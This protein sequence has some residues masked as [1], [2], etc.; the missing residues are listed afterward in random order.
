MK[1]ITILYRQ[2]NYKNADK[3]IGSLRQSLKHSLR[4]TPSNPTK[5]LE[6]DEDKSSENQ[7]YD[8]ESNKIK[9]LDSLSQDERIALIK[10]I[11]DD[12]KINVKANNIDTTNK[13][14]LSKYR[15]KLNK[16]IKQSVDNPELCSYLNQI[17]SAKT[18]LDADE[19]KTKFGQ[20]QMS[21][22]K[23]K[24]NCLGKFIELHNK[25]LTPSNKKEFVL[26][27]AVIQEAFFKIPSR[28][29]VEIPLKD[30]IQIQ[31]SFYKR[32]FPDYSLK[33]LVVHCD[34]ADP[35]SHIFVSTKNNKTNKYDLLKAQ[36]AFVE[37]NID[38][39][40]LEVLNNEPSDYKRKKLQAEYFQ[41]LFYKHANSYLHN[42][43]LEATVL[44]KTE[45]NKARLRE[46]EKDAKLPKIQRQFNLNNL[47]L[48]EQQ[49]EISELKTE[50]AAT[51]EELSSSKKDYELESLKHKKLKFANF[52]L[53]ED[54]K[55]LTSDVQILS[56]RF[57]AM[58]NSLASIAASIS[59]Y[60][61]DLM[62]KVNSEKS[63]YEIEAKQNLFYEQFET[64][65]PVN[66]IIDEMADNVQGFSTQEKV[67]SLKL[68]GI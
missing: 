66:E 10:S 11:V 59:D 46:I 13:N 61:I 41:V 57:K 25:V 38:K 23:D 4:I 51:N 33:A 60:V 64:L 37:K 20:F 40:R 56:D 8:F 53:I 43:N 19:E 54:N 63:R 45:E 49:E 17:I 28:N 16:I 42:Y 36:Y 22:M 21:R 58:T 48:K 6:W 31:A 55:K 29:N 15:A 50:L 2:I 47:R 1:K 26:N 35:H 12:V 14:D 52:K 18:N 3:G 32:N 34:E 30:L 5:K 68:P 67:R 62:K 9:K 44:E 7:I 24:I 65:D 39:E 27:E